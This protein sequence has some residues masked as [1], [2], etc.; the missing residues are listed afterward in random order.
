MVTEFATPDTAPDLKD[1]EVTEEAPAAALD[2]DIN[3]VTEVDE[4]FKLDGVVVTGPATPDAVPDF[5]VDVV[6]E[7]A[8]A[9]ALD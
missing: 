4:L 7:K 9:P 3:V 5:E 8:P 6:T 1:A 2:F